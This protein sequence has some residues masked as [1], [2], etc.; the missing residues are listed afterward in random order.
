MH[1]LPLIR[2]KFVALH[3]CIIIPTYNNEHALAEVIDGVLQYTGDVI[4]VNDGST[5]HTIS[6]LEQFPQIQTIHIPV[7]TGKGWALRQGFKHAI[8]K[9]YR[10]AI[11]IDS[12]GQHF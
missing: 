4:V 6:I 1:D 8:D 10:Y 7:N 2:Q 11:T 3:C 12:D 9:G 5:D